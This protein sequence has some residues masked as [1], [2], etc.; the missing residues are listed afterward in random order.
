MYVSFIHSFNDSTYLH[1]KKKRGRVNK[2]GKNRRIEKWQVEFCDFIGIYE[3]M[4]ELLLLMF[5]EV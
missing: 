5:L 3:H 4:K 1:Q 2:I